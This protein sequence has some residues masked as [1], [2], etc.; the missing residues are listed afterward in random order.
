MNKVMLTAIMLVA[1]I[2]IA[3]QQDKIPVT[4]DSEVAREYYLKG[5]DLAERLRYQD[6]VENFRLALKHDP[7]F[8]MANYSM[9]IFGETPN[10]RL[11]YFEKAKSVS[12]QASWAEQQLILALEAGMSAHTRKQI[13]IIEG[14]ID[15]Y[16]R[17]ERVLNMLGNIYFG[18]QDYERAIEI[19]KRVLKI[20][21]E[22]SQTYNQLGYAYRFLGDYVNAENAFKKYI[23]LIPDDPNPYDSYA[24]L[25]LKMG[26]YEISIEN[27]EKALKIDPNFTNSYMGL[28][29]N[30]NIKREYKTA[31]K[32]LK[33]FY[34]RAR[35]Q[36]QKRI[37]IT[38]LIISHID[39][40]DF[41]GAMKWISRRYDEARASNDTV[42]IAGDI[43][44]MGYWYRI[45]G[46]PDAAMKKYQEARE[47]VEQADIPQSIKD[48]FRRGYPY[49]EA[50]IAMMKKDFDRADKFESEFRAETEKVENPVQ[51]RLA[52]ELA[53]QI[54]LARGDYAA[55]IE[56]LEK[57]NKQN[58]HNLFRIAQAYEGMGELEKALEYYDQA[59]NFNGFMDI[60]YALIRTDAEKKAAEM[61]AKLRNL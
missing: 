61:K 49:Q 27:Y 17:D 59:A 8:P 4:T 45:T 35:S 47:L 31:R 55:A 40:G 21:P 20:N 23:Q 50:V 51:M 16:P 37:A 46:Q 56:W 2:F 22:F 32:Y 57:A 7:E 26:E 33:E 11:S 19:Y 13:E 52:N 42:L 30:Y 60:E 12:K 41:E 53:G 10:E 24:E 39:E 15:A 58:A 44:L 29:S 36:D 25:L 48:N 9:A 3:C 38:A 54:A 14:L 1:L 5:R 34:L 28:A 6:A 18:Q 43:N